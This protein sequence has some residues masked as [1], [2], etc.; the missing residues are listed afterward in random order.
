[1]NSL[2][3]VWAYVVAEKVPKMKRTRSIK[4]KKNLGGG[5]ESRKILQRGEKM[6]VD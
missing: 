1:M 2:L 6:S 4:S 3:Y 5:T